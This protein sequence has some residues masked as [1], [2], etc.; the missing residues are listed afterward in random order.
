MFIGKKSGIQKTWQTKFL[1]I[2]HHDDWLF[3][4]QNHFL[5][6]VLDQKPFNHS[7]VEQKTIKVFIHNRKITELPNV[8]F[9]IAAFEPL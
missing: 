7:N 1:W 2:K 5:R 8:V 9:Y 4:S 3:S 6:I